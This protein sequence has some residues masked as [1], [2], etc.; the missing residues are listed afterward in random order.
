MAQ[1]AQDNHE[2]LHCLITEPT[3][4]I[5]LHECIWIL[6]TTLHQQSSSGQQQASYFNYLTHMAEG[7]G[8]IVKDHVDPSTR[9]GLSRL[10]SPNSLPA[11]LWLLW[12]PPLRLL[13]RL[14]L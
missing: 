8:I 3:A 13:Q 2:C 7:A 14:Q 10:A 9:C 1:Q 6:I 12:R 11:S 5:I 4:L